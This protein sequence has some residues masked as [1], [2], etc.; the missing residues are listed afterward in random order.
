[1]AQERRALRGHVP[2]AAAGIAAIDRL[3]SAKSLNL[4]IGLPLRNQAALASFLRELYD[5]ASPNYRRYLTPEQFTERFGPTE[6]DYQT[7]IA[8]ATANGL[9]VTGTH[10]D[11]MLLN[12]AGSVASVESAFRLTLRVYP[13]P[14]EARTFF[15]PNTEPSVESNLPIQDI[16]GLSDFQLPRPKLRKPVPLARADRPTDLPPSEASY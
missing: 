11:R 1:M 7:V 16:S 13:H 4:A 10:S 15:A 14:T 12:V 8:F 5:P 6:A 9:A 2:T 3:P